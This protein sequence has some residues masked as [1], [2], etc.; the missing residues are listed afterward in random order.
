MREYIDPPNGDVVARSNRM[1]RR[2]LL[3]VLLLGIGEAAFAA[4]FV[5]PP[6]REFARQAPAIVVASALASHTELVNDRIVTITTMSI[7]E[8][9]KGDIADQ[10]IDIYEPG[11][12]YGNR[13]TM[14]PGTPRF[15]DGERALL[16]LSRPG[17]HWMVVDLTLGKFHF[18]TDILG[19]DVVLRDLSD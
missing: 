8:V 10:T 7:E 9:I 1:I 5:V 16:F 13:V 11:G 15:S 18:D 3:L 12:R 17:D 19:H 2:G 14:I 4:S 6:D